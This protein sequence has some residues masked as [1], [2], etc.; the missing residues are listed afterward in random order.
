MPA[1][2]V[3]RSWAAV[4]AGKGELSKIIPG[5]LNKEILVRGSTE[6]SLT[7]RSPQ[8]IVQTV[9]GIFERKGAIAAPKLP[10]GDVIVT[11]QD[12]E[13]N[14]WYA[15]NGGWIGTA[16]GEVA[17]EARRTFVVLVEGMLK[18]DLKDVMEVAF[19]K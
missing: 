18:R 8:G 12:A 17:K 15:K 3:A 5:R 14:G 9:N 1:T 6:P 10:S 4:V 16:F 19:S 2:T 13:T 7:R 11:F